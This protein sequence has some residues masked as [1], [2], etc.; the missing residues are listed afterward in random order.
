MKSVAYALPVKDQAA[1][2]SLADALVGE[3]GDKFHQSRKEHGF[4]RIKVF[5]QKK[6][7]PMVIFYF[8]GGDMVH[9]AIQRRHAAKDEFEDWLESAIEKATG[10]K[11]SE[12]SGSGLPSDLALDWHRDK[13]VSRS[14]H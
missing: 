12:V 4:D 14:H 9:D 3:H 2:A 11:I 6:P 5:L 1:A 8:E 10:H 13:G 7:Q